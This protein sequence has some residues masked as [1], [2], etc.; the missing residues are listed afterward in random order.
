MHFP[1]YCA[2][3]SA[4]CAWCCCFCHSTVGPAHLGSLP[5]FYNL[6]FAASSV[7]VSCIACT[8]RC[9]H[10][11]VE[12]QLSSPRIART[13]RLQP[14]ARSRASRT[15]MLG[16]TLT[17]E[18]SG[19]R[20]FAVF[21]LESFVAV[22]NCAALPIVAGVRS[23][24]A[25]RPST[26]KRA[27]LREPRKPAGQLEFGLRGLSNT[28]KDNGCGCGMLVELNMMEE[29]RRTSWAH[30]TQAARKRRTAGCNIWHRKDSMGILSIELV[31]AS[32]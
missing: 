1:R 17:V 20:V 8:S 29:A 6:A 23:S 25:P 26:V 14:V 12:G 9:F 16:I 10:S 22:D 24:H 32:P 27:A 11:A 7:A 21:A 15:F 28:T 31:L 2:A 13:I 3:G 19:T 4:F 5:P 18:L 30:S